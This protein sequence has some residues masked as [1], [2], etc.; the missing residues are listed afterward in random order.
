MIPMS[1]VFIDRKK[2]LEHLNKLKSLS[3]SPFIAIVGRR[4][5]GKT[6]LVQEFIKNIEN[7]LYFFIE[8]K[9]NSCVIK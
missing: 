2:E 7:S 3:P 4:R 1:I 6:R 8:E 9:K 5:V